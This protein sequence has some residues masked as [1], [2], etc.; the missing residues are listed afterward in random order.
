MPGRKAGGFIHAGTAEE[1]ELSRSLRYLRRRTCVCIEP[2]GSHAPQKRYR[3]LGL[4]DQAREKE[5]GG[6]R[7]K[8]RFTLERPRRDDLRVS[9]LHR[10]G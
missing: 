1:E 3:N 7:R 4:S 8:E 5:R 10:G 6:E 9:R 2:K